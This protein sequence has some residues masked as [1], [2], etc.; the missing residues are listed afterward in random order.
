MPPGR[1]LAER[2]AAEAALLAAAC[3]SSGSRSRTSRPAL[4]RLGKVD[5]DRVE[6]ALV[7]QRRRAEQDLVDVEVGV[8][9][10]LDARVVLRAS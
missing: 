8:E 2:D 1:I 9:V 5:E 3:P 6:L 7:L 10:E 4:Q